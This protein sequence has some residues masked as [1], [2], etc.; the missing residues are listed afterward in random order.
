MHIADGII[1]TNICIAAHVVSAGILYVSGKKMPVEEI[2]GVGIM[3]AALFVASLIHFPFAGTSIHLGL[4]GMAGIILGK[5]AFPAIFT[6]LLF[7]T[8]IFQHGGLITLGVNAL[9]MGA[10]AYT[11]WLIWKMVKIPEF[12]RALLAG[13]FG[14]IVPA[15]LMAT[16]FR[17]SGYGKGIVYLFSVYLVAAGIESAITF[18]AVKFFRRV[19][20]GILK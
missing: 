8:L 18:S 6:A 4:F 3:G 2:P 13:F 11:A 7:Q 17:L 20:P 12:I 5:H 16:E 15:L 19:K 14:I 1:D 9:N 10:G